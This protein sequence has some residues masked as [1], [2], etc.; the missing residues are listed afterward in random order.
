MMR[1]TE[2]VPVSITTQVETFIR[3]KSFFWA[4]LLSLWLVLFTIAAKISFL[5]EFLLT[6][7][8]L[9]SFGMFKESGPTDEQVKQASFIYWFFGTGWEEKYGSFDKYQAA[10]NKKDRLLQM[11]ARCVGPDAGYVATSECVLAA[12][13]SLLSDADKLPAGG[14][15]TSAS[16]FKD[17]GIYGRLENYGVRFEIVENH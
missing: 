7:P 5:K 2:K 15:Y 11:V 3:I 13:L 9:C 14:V 16:A 4:T 12:A 17:T 8:G 6:H 10:P 1:V